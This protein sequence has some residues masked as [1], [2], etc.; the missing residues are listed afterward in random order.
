VPRLLAVV[1]AVTRPGRLD[2]AVRLA[3][4]GAGALPEVSATVLSLAGHHISF[5][6]GRPLVIRTI[7]RGS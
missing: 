6:D 3:A 5:A 7:P 4:D 2:A 1:G